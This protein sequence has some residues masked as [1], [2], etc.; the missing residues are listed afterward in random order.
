M[1]LAES[2]A[3]TAQSWNVIC[4]IFDQIVETVGD[5]KISNDELLKLMTAGFEDV[6]IGLVPVTTDCCLLYTSRCV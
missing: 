1:G 2:A 3:E 6:E 4:G 5:A